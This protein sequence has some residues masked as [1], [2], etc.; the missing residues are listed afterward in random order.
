M[1]KNEIGSYLRHRI[2]GRKYYR[3]WKKI[4]DALDQNPRPDVKII[5]KEAKSASWRTKISGPIIGV[6][7]GGIPSV[8]NDLIM[9]ND[10]EVIEKKSIALKDIEEIE[11]I[12][13]GR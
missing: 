8:P 10:L 12:Q 7:F 3:L 2:K 11:E 13:N 4:L 6:L 1:S 9:I 5:F